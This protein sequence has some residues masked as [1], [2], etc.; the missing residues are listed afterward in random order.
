MKNERNEMLRRE[1]A[2]G[3]PVADLMA[4]YGISRSRLYQLV[5]PS[6]YDGQRARRKEKLDAK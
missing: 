3:M 6:A 1:Y 4:I 2:E 5:N